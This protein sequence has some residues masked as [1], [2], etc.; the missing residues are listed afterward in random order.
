MTTHDPRSH[1]PRSHDPRPTVRLLGTHGVPAAYGGFETAAE[2]IGYYLRDRGWRVVV[3]CQQP[4]AGATH[5]DVWRGLER[6]HIHEERE[7]WL[8]TASFDA[9]SIRHVLDHTGE[10]GPQDACIT[11]GYNTGVFNVAQR[12]RRIPNVINMDGMEWTRRRWGLAKQGI[13]LANERFAGVVGDVL[14]ADHPV[15]ARYLSRHFGAKRVETITYGGVPVHD[16]PTQPVRDLRLEPGRYA[17]V[18]C[19]PIPENSLV[20]IVQ[21]WSARRRGMPLVVLGNFTR[22]DAYHREVLDAAGDEVLFPGA[23]YDPQVVQALR[24][25][26]A[27]YLHGHTVGGTN[28]SLVE[29]MAAGSAVV[30]HDNHYNRWV[31]DKGAR[32]FRDSHDLADTL[33]TLL[34]DPR[35]R[36]EMGR[37]SRRRFEAEFTWERIGSQYEEALLRALRRHGRSAVLPVPS[38]LPT[39]AGLAHI[40][41]HEIHAPRTDAPARTGGQHVMTQEVGA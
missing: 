12:L 32:F 10:T 14:V 21:G 39:M 25:H 36:A 28:P 9:K 20:E 31:V 3:Y 19:R 35:L 40:D 7:G 37:Q 38:A 15:I 5:T 13:L 23:I 22:A 1:D 29:A 16:A 26:A 17:T 27:L 11:F 18:I 24:F 4:G 6:V 30:A 33:D 8:G 41:G 2:H 34:A